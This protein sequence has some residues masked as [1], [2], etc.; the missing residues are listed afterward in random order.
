[1]NGFETVLICNDAKDTENYRSAVKW[2]NIAVNM[3][4]FLEKN[5]VYP[6]SELQKD[7]EDTVRELISL[8]LHVEAREAFVNALK[9]ALELRHG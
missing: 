8:R 6:D 2:R 7:I 5:T 4:Q 1:M 9:K 3:P